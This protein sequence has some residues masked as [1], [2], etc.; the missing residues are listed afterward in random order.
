[1]WVVLCKKYAAVADEA[2][3]TS[4]VSGLKKHFDPV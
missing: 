4:G 3:V 1:M 2:G